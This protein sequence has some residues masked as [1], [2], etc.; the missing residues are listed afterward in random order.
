M[1]RY[2]AQAMQ[3]LSPQSRVP[4]RSGCLAAQFSGPAQGLP[5]QNSLRGGQQLARGVVAECNGRAWRWLEA[6]VA[7]G[8]VRHKVGFLQWVGAERV[9][10]LAEPAFGH[11]CVP[12]SEQ[13]T[14][15]PLVQLALRAAPPA[16]EFAAQQQPG[17][18]RGHS[19]CC[20]GWWHMVMASAAPSERE[21]K[22]QGSQQ[23][24]VPE[25]V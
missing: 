4:A 7:G 13:H 23:Q 8:A 5:P 16:A 22:K 9:T 14:H 17:H 10:Q 19:R 11:P 21:T 25:R 24:A 1:A 15:L 2:R 6:A 3:L 20:Q 18:V 12:T